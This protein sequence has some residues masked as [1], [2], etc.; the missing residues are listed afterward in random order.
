[1]IDYILDN[2]NHFLGDP[3]DAR[4]RRVVGAFRL[5]YPDVNVEMGKLRSSKF[6]D[7]RVPGSFL[8]WK[9]GLDGCPSDCSFES[10]NCS[11]AGTY[12]IQLFPGSSLNAEFE[13]RRLR[14]LDSG[15]WAGDAKSVRNR[16]VITGYEEFAYDGTVGELSPINHRRFYDLVLGE[17]RQRYLDMNNRI[18]KLLWK[19]DFKH[20]L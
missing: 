3:R 10:E 16:T 2:L 9:I 1:M 5:K 6:I 4:W 17:D 12:T 13:Y 19:I 20:V 14:K 18:G 11:T 8:V 15:I 7:Y